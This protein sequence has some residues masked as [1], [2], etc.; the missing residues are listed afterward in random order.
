M[1]QEY[2]L[3]FMGHDVN[4]TLYSVAIDRT[5]TLVLPRNINPKKAYLCIVG[6]GNRLSTGHPPQDDVS[7]RVRYTARDFHHVL[8]EDEMNVFW[9]LGD[10]QVAGICK[11]HTRLFSWLSC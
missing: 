9:R 4:V 5:F 11:K 10:K 6:R 3:T 1:Q 7:V 2:L 8:G